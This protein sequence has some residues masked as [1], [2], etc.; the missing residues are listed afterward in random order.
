MALARDI[1]SAGTLTYNSVIAS[2]N[3]PIPPGERGIAAKT[4]ANGVITIIYDTMFN[5]AVGRG[6]GF[7]AAMAWVYAGVVALLLAL[8]YLILREKSDKN[9]VYEQKRIRKAGISDT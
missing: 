8:A 2:S 7:A 1:S 4:I 3:V 9:V 5:S 6:Y